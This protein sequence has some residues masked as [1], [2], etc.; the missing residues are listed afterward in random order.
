MWLKHIYC[1]RHKGNWEC[2]A[3]PG[4]S[5][6][7]SRG[8]KKKKEKKTSS[9]S[10]RWFL[11]VYGAMSAVSSWAQVIVALLNDDTSYR[12]RVQRFPLGWCCEQFY[13]PLLW[14]QV[15]L[16]WFFFHLIQM[17][18]NCKC[19]HKNILFQGFCTYF[20]RG[21]IKALSKGCQCEDNGSFFFSLF[22]PTTQSLTEQ[23][24]KPISEQTIIIQSCS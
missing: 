5:L 19:A 17:W 23:S 14:N 8:K 15:I 1:T 7:P 16:S 11:W 21:S 4:I 13:T 22:F 3:N 10:R 12:G 2:A 24:T 6:S 18:N 9:T 20:Q